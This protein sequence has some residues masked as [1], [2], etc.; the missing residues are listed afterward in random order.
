MPNKQKAIGDSVMK[1][2]KSLSESEIKE[3]Y[4]TW[5]SLLDAFHL[6]LVSI[7]EYEQEYDSSK[8]SQTEE[9][10]TALME[11]Q[12]VIQDQLMQ[13]KDERSD[14]SDS[15]T[16]DAVKKLSKI[17]RASMKQV[18]D[19]V[20]PNT[21]MILEGSWK[22]FVHILD[23][24]ILSHDSQIM[25]AVRAAT[26]RTEADCADKLNQ[27]QKKLDEWQ[28]KLEAQNKEVD[29]LQKGIE[30]LRDDKLQFESIIID[31]EAEIRRL[32]E[33][34]DLSDIHDIMMELG[35]FL[36]D[37]EQ[38][39]ADQANMLNEIGTLINH[40]WKPKTPPPEKVETPKPE[41]QQSSRDDSR[42]GRKG[43]PVRDAHSQ[44]KI[45]ELQAEIES[46]LD[47]N[48]DLNRKLFQAREGLK[49][50]RTILPQAHLMKQEENM[51]PVMSGEVAERRPADEVA[52]KYDP[53]KPARIYI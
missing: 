26:E 48:E 52:T 33:P 51:A 2:F 49:K 46:L 8:L 9:V 13:T 19:V 42:A 43:K 18:V 37:T 14:V 11:L 44:R 22:S 5:T 4:A 30:R 36:D 1:S 12:T 20:D 53:N 21:V 23:T 32:S 3:F 29:R 28:S 47:E 27:T 50:K 16:F 45:K 41:S 24:S 6:M 15:D 38:R 39:Q 10:N 25:Y 17:F 35:N 40:D 7:H 31:R 34:P